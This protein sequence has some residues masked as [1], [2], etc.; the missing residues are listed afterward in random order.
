MKQLITLLLCLTIGLL[1]AQTNISGVIN[2]YTPVQDIDPCTGEVTVTDATGFTAGD[3][4]MIIQMKGANIVEA[5]NAAFGT[6]M[7]LG[8]CGLDKRL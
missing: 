8:N 6:V 4:V 3:K 2:S 7:D 5:N 1:T